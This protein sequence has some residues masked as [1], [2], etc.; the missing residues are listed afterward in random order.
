MLRSGAT[1]KAEETFGQGVAN[2]GFGTY[3][4]RLMN[5]TT[6]GQNAA[7]GVGSQGSKAAENIAGTQ[8]S[9]G[10]ARASIYGQ[11]AQGVGNAAANYGNNSLYREKTNSLYGG[12][13]GAGFNSGIDSVGNSI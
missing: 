9:A 4:N 3:Y 6:M 10:G 5:L 2:Q 8:V 12:G 11:A 7:A 13:G 1:L